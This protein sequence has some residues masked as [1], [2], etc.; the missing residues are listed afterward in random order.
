MSAGWCRCQRRVGC[1]GL[2]IVDPF[3]I[4][5]DA[6]DE[7]VLQLVVVAVKDQAAFLPASEQHHLGPD[8]REGR[9]VNLG[10]WQKEGP[11]QSAALKFEA[12]PGGW[13]PKGPA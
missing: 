3:K 9:R 8:V 6:S 10:G 4:D 5:D 13:T 11:R 7:T 12:D 1:P 2:F